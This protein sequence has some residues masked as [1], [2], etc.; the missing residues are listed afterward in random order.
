MFRRFKKIYL[1]NISLFIC[2]GALFFNY[3][4]NNNLYFIEL[5][6]VEEGNS[7][8]YGEDLP[9]CERAKRDIFGRS[10][11][12]VLSPILYA[13]YKR[14]CFTGGEC[15]LSI[16]TASS[17]ES[18]RFFETLLIPKFDHYDPSS[19]KTCGPLFSSDR[20]YCRLFES[21]TFEKNVVGSLWSPERKLD[22]KFFL[23]FVAL[24][25]LFNIFWLREN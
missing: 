11:E 3:K 1:I 2:V 8:E 5:N 15:N 22:Y 14:V 20:R 4:S 19:Y 10:F 9:F 16:S 21:C 18:G 23:G 6:Y 13:E 25:I 12:Y 24:F 17:I 7:V